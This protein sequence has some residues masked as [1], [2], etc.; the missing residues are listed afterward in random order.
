M[1]Q[2]NNTYSF[3]VEAT[4][5]VDTTMTTVWQ[6]NSGP[7][8]DTVNVNVYLWVVCEFEGI[9]MTG[10]DFQGKVTQLSPFDI[11]EPPPTASSSCKVSLT[12]VL[13]PQ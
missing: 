6:T 1:M 13:P 11:H 5:D 10:G 7:S 9:T 4:T 8:T 3:S 2:P 12:P